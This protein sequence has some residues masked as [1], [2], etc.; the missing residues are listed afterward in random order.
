MIKRYLML[1]VILLGL[2]SCESTVRPSFEIMSEP[3]LAMYNASL[4]IDEQIIC[5]EEI[6]GWRIFSG[7]ISFRE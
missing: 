2:S 3:E 7:A 4:S 6:E 1:L 5:R